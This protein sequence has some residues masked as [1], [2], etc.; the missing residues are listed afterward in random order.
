MPSSPAPSSSAIPP[1]KGPPTPPIDEVVA[2]LS[3]ELSLKELWRI[4]SRIGMSAEQF[5]NLTEVSPHKLRRGRGGEEKIDRAK[6]EPILRCAKVFRRVVALCN[7]DETAARSWLNAPA[8]VLKN[9][10]PIEVAE[11]NPGAKNVEA[12]VAQLEKAAGLSA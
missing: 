7:K 8:P 10:K 12:L 5:E 6:N 1:G 4:A 2:R 3:E 9:R 11:T